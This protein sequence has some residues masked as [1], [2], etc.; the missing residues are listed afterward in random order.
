MHKT[1]AEVRKAV[2][3][4]LGRSVDIELDNDG[5]VIVYT[6]LKQ[7]SFSGWLAKVASN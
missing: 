2:E 3:T 6:G 1:M 7:K 4:A 5:Q